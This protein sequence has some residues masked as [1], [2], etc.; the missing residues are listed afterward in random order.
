LSQY[1]RC[2]SPYYYWYWYKVLYPGT[3]KIIGRNKHLIYFQPL[4]VIS[5]NFPFVLTIFSYLVCT[6]YVIWPR[7]AHDKS[8]HLTCFPLSQ[9]NKLKI[10]W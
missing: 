7:K 9:R 8:N 5:S 3:L 2:S 4:F 6:V 10:Y 1:C